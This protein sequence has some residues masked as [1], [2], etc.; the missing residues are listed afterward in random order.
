MVELEPSTV[1]KAFVVNALKGGIRVDGRKPYDFRTVK[2]ALGPSSG[3]CEAQLGNTR[4]LANV[5]AE[6]VRPSPNNPAD[7][8]LQFNTSFSPMASPT[9]EAGRIS[10]EEVIVSRLLEKALRK[11]RAVDTEGLCI[12]AGE[13]VWSV[14]VDIHVLD[15]EGNLV[16]CACI[17][18]VAALMH[19]RR[20]DVVVEGDSIKIFS[21]DERNPIPLS[22]HHI[23]ICITFGFFEKGER[24]VVDPFHLEEQVQ[25]GDVTFVVNS[26]REL[27]TISKSGGAPLDLEQIYQCAEI[28]SLK[29]AEVTELIRSA[30]SKANEKK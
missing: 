18:A 12:V 25:D 6:I 22:V 16:D 26:H 5:S 21:P 1:E 11:S 14:R 19:F 29:A 20:P 17:A 23:P 4:V 28:A 7:G 13:K 9:F 27:C 15:H 3:R 8:F 30:L 10:E 24:M 2:I